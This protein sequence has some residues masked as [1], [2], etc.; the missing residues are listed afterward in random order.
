MKSDYAQTWAYYLSK[1]CNVEIL[2]VN[3]KLPETALISDAI[4]FYLHELTSECRVD[5][6]LKE[7]FTSWLKSAQV[8]SNFDLQKFSRAELSRWLRA[9]GMKSIYQFDRSKNPTTPISLVQADKPLAPRERDTLLNII[10]AL[11]ELIQTAKSGRDSDT[12]VIK[13]LLDN[14]SDKA[15]I[16]ER[17]LQ[18]K[19]AAAKR[20]LLSN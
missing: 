13:E 8:R 11:V 9:I 3:D 12:A 20:S 5:D 1:M 19:F 2:G 6:E 15:G 4:K 18:E 17:T 7:T 14:Y 10:G 16:K